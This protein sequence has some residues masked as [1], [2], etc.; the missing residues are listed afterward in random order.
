MTYC[1][2]CV[3]F[4]VSICSCANIF[5]QNTRIWPDVTA[6]CHTSIGPG[7]TSG[8]SYTATELGS[9][10]LLEHNLHNSH[11]WTRNKGVFAVMCV[12]FRSAA[13]DP[14][15]LH[16]NT[17]FLLESKRFWQWCNRIAGFM[18]FVHSTGFKITRKHN[19]SE[20]GCF[21]VRDGR[22]IGSF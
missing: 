20:T 22:Q 18:G 4:D 3:K 19:V 2:S 9:K 12:V 6:C 5:E 7:F 1:R 14:Y 11:C 13:H 21:R 15:S 8:N 10:A 17:I 16:T